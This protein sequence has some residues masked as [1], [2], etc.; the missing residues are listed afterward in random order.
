MCNVE[1]ARK[2]SLTLNAVYVWLRKLLD[3]ITPTPPMTM[4]KRRRGRIRQ[5]QT[6]PPTTP[7]HWISPLAT[8]LLLPTLHLLLNSTTTTNPTAPDSA[9]RNPAATHFATAITASKP[10]TLPGVVIKEVFTGHKCQYIDCQP[11]TR[12]QLY[13]MARDDLLDAQVASIKETRE[14]IFLEVRAKELP[15]I[16]S[17]V[18][19]EDQ[20]I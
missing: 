5:N 1:E 17:Q 12:Q 20:N 14:K 10:I 3:L 19:G 13:D 15:E 9:D 11:D 6:T 7:L 2:A 16:R 4:S 18:R 8:P